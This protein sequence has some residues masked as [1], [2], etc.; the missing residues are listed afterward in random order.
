MSE[1]ATGSLLDAITAFESLAVDEH[2]EDERRALG[3]DIYHRA[4][5]RG[6][7]PPGPAA[8]RVLDWCIAF[9]QDEGLIDGDTM[10]S[11]LIKA[12]RADPSNISALT[13]YIREVADTSY[14]YTD[15]DLTRVAA[16]CQGDARVRMLLLGAIVE[17]LIEEYLPNPVYQRAIREPLAQAVEL[18]ADASAWAA[19]RTFAAE[20]APYRAIP[21]ELFISYTG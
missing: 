2:G 14:A 21:E 17:Y 9:A 4:F 8:Q 11:L 18:G 16:G 12:I 7:W 5:Q 20:A 19:A 3:L 15:D 10:T 1:P 6:A 13:S